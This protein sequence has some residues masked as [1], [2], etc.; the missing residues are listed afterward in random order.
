M[1]G[2]KWSMLFSYPR[3]LITYGIITTDRNYGSSWS[4]SAPHFNYLITPYFITTLWNNGCASIETVT[5]KNTQLEILLNIFLLSRYFVSWNNLYFIFRQKLLQ[6]A[7]KKLEYILGY[8][9][10]I[11]YCYYYR[12]LGNTVISLLRPLFLAAWHKKPLIFL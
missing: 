3:L 11:I 5:K 7:T 12:Y 6:S 9:Y 1:A 4:W 10:I 8:Y 2:T